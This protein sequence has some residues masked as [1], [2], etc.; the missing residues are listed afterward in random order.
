[1]RRA[2]VAMSEARENAETTD[3]ERQVE[4]ATASVRVQA[5][6]LGELDAEQAAGDPLSLG[7]LM[8]VPVRVTVQVGRTSMA[9]AELMTLGPGSLIE[10]DR[11]AHEPVDVLVNGRVVARGE[12]VTIDDR[13]GVRITSV[14]KND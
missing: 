8:D 7:S 3:L 5:A 6:E 13:Y 9:L 1:M 4:A 11:E 14:Q 2:D 10:L 12:V